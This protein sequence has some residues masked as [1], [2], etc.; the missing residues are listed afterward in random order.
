MPQH[1]CKKFHLLPHKTISGS[2]RNGTRAKHTPMQMNTLRSIQLVG[3]GM[4]YRIMG[5]KSK[6]ERYSVLEML[7]QNGPRIWIRTIILHYL[8]LL[9]A[10]G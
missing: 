10:S 4:N 1:Q 2:P 3:S 8:P 5:C 9:L 7:I 6:A